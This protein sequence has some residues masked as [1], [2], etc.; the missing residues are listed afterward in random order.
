MRNKGT[1]ESKGGCDVVMYLAGQG[2][3]G[4]SWARINWIR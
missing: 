4:E 1:E 3:K 2:P